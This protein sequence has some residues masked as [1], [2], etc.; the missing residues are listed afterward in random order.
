MVRALLKDIAAAQVTKSGF[1]YP[2]SFPAFRDC[3]GVPHNYQ[4]DNNIFFTAIGT[5][6]LQNLLPVL[7]GEDKQTAA[8][9]I[10]NAQQTFPYYRNWQG[11]PFY[12]FW[13]TGKNI[14]PGT[15]FIRNFNGLL[16][17]GE[18][19][20]DAVMILLAS[21]ANDSL[22]HVLKQRMIGVSNG[23]RKRVRSTFTKYRDYQAYSTYLGLQMPPDFDL[24]VHCNILYFMLKAHLPLV[25]QDTATI[26]L[27]AAM[28]KNREYMRAPVFI[29]PYYAR[30][31]VLMYHLARLI[32]DFHI[33]ALDSFKTQLVTDMQHE[34]VRAGDL[35]DRILLSTSL[36]RLGQVPQPLH[37]SNISAFEHS[38][39]DRFIF[40]Q[41]R[42]A[43]WYPGLLKKIF[44][45]LG[46]LR[47]NF[48][49]PVFNKILLLE[50]LLQKRRI[51]SA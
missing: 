45:H 29:S 32:G 4:P 41:A 5:F 28:M 6:A 14:L 39:T 47:Y 19:A 22:C 16:G 36:I 40:F 35:M 9:I 2:G 26:H 48:Y 21:G 49:C 38:G 43:F 18:D 10:N 11:Q 31:P 46:Y 44:L 42:A 12:N 51:I 30:R 7:E 8:R 3:A 34:M 37:I 13:P 50:Y 15:L 27:I 23:Q 17:M 20:D 24:A 25:K 1:F 33:P